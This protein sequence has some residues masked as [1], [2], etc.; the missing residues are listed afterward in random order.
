MSIYE[1]VS[2]F[3]RVATRTWLRAMIAVEVQFEYNSLGGEIL[4]GWSRTGYLIPS[5]SLIAYSLNLSTVATQG[6][7]DGE[8]LGASCGEAKA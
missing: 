4:R 5:L 1:S 6:N 7:D 3:E 8:R 2:I